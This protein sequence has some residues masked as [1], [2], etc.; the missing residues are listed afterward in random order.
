MSQAKIPERHLTTLAVAR[1]LLLHQM[2]ALQRPDARPHDVAP[3]MLW[4]PPGVGK[5]ELVRKLCEEHGWDFID[6]RLAQRDPVDLRGLP[7]PE[8]GVVRW[9][10]SSDW[11]RADRP[12]GIL[13]FDELTAADRTLQ[14][15]AYELILDRRLGDTYR[16]PPGW[17]VCGAGNRSE[18]ASVALPMS[19]ALANRFLHLEVQADVVPWTQWAH[20]NSIRPE[21]VAFLRARPALLLDLEQS[22]VQRGWPSPRSWTRVSHLLEA[23]RSEERPLS[24]E[25]LHAGLVGLV[26]VG[27]ALE[28][29]A[30][31]RRSADLPDLLDLVSGTLTLTTLPR[32]ADALHALVT[33]LARVV[34][35]A[36]DRT[37]ALGIA[38]HLAAELPPDFAALFFADVTAVAPRGALQSITSHPALERLRAAHGHLFV[39]PKTDEAPAKGP[40]WQSGRRK[41]AGD[42]S[43]A[44]SS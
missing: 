37:K 36:A 38:L 4:G 41:R 10:P 25:A 17:L 29:E 2:H 43:E 35:V 26:G 18:D 16:L 22:N 28:F 1:E 27:P 32:S 12:R 7:V 33:G 31:L 30:F 5:S 21:V 8:D 3:I 42:P 20:A 6:V 34:W 15:A 24:S 44:R 13:L 11:P 14:V 9:L 23:A 40:T 19:A 39:Q